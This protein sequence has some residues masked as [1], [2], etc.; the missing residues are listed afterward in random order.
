MNKLTIPPHDDVTSIYVAAQNKKLS[1]YPHIQSILPSIL[2]CYQQYDRAGGR[3]SKVT[4]IALNPK[5]REQLRKHYEKP[6]TCFKHIE[7]MRDL[8]SHKVCPMCGSTHSGTL[9]HFLPKEDYP[10]YAVYSKNL[11][12][13]CS[14]NSRRGRLLTGES[15]E[16]RLLH[17]Y[18]DDCLTRRL[19]IAKFEQLGAIPKTSLTINCDKRDPL[20]PAINFHAQSI[21]LK[22][23]ILKHISDTWSKL[24]RRPGE[25]VRNLNKN[26]LDP[27]TVKQ[28]L[29][30]ELD[31]LDAFYESK[32]NWRS[33]FVAGLLDE[34]VL[35][36]ITQRL[37]APG[38]KPD[39]PLGP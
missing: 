39:S 7:S 38:R 9:D 14:C 27:R 17:P 19:L 29:L 11:V 22:S 4:K 37:S 16:E 1:S 13:A 5:L 21:V 20:Y 12:P 6:P 25:V 32:N 36:W 28:I 24:Y 31:Y 34:E 2:T 30:E 3:S 33:V 10:Q 15:A 35:N 8:S 26:H 18:F 23:S